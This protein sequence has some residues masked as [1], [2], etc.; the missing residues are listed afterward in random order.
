[1]PPS[2]PASPSGRASRLRVWLIV[3]AAILAGVAIVVVFLRNADD[4]SSSAPVSNT[5]RYLTGPYFDPS[6]GTSINVPSTWRYGTLRDGTVYFAENTAYLDLYVRGE[7]QRLPGI[8][9]KA[10]LTTQASVVPPGTADSD[11]LDL[12]F[13]SS[14]LPLIVEERLTVNGLP[15]RRVLRRLPKGD[16]LPSGETLAYTRTHIQYVYLSGLTL[17]RFTLE[18]DGDSPMTTVDA[19]DSAARS[20]S[21]SSRS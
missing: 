10:W 12:P 1:M 3:I 4:G 18:V 15:T 8:G 6:T 19:F 17:Y 5:E 20:F 13:D 14:V 11:A 7:D 21:V 9:F 16:A 2:S